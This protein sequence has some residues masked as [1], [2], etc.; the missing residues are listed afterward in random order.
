MGDKIKEAIAYNVILIFW[1][2]VALGFILWDK[3]TAD[4]LEVGKYIVA[5]HAVNSGLN[6]Q[7]GSYLMRNQVPM[8]GMNQ[9]MTGGK[10]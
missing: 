2:L 3:H 9:P 8:Y 4:W 10:V 7:F 6:T 5:Q 1:M